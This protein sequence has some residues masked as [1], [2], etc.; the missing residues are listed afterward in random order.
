MHTETPL[1]EWVTKEHLAEAHPVLN[2]S[3]LKYLIR[4]R[5]DNGLSASGAVSKVGGRVLSHK[6]KFAAWSA[7]RAC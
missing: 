3:Q 6:N 7:T 2:L 4:S 5:K 1:D